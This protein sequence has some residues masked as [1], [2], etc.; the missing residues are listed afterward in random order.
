MEKTL[1]LSLP[2]IVALDWVGEQSTS[3]SRGRT[4]L[5]INILQIAAV[6]WIDRQIQETKTETECRDFLKKWGHIS[7][8]QSWEDSS[9]LLTPA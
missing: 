2:L 3:T 9:S 5:F 6:V 7:E 4:R 1:I 8:S